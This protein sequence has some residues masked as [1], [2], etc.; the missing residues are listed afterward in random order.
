MAQSNTGY[1]QQYQELKEQPGL[2]D[3]RDQ[4][5]LLEDQLDQLVLMEPQELKDLLVLLERLEPLELKDPLVLLELK[6]PLEL[7]VQL[8]LSKGLELT[9]HL[10]LD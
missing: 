8:Y 6:E 5:G 1:P 2:L 9:A 3:H 4:R 7:L 10:E